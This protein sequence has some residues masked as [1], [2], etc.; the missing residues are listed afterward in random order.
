MNCFLRN[1]RNNGLTWSSYY[2]DVISDNTY[3]SNTRGYQSLKIDI[4]TK[5]QKSSFKREFF[6]TLR[7]MYED[8]S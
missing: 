7:Q 6:R 1:I 5:C 2:P 4:Q 8:E 3:A